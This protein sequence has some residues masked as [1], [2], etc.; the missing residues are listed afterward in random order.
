MVIDRHGIVVEERLGER[1]AFGDGDGRE[2]EPVG[3]VPHRIDVRKAGVRPFIDHDR[4]LALHSTPTSPRPRVRVLGAP[5]RRIHDE[6][7]GDFLALIDRRRE[8]GA[9]SLDP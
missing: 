7:G 1:P 6:I 3:H 5:A 2:V 9:A 8:G 4:A